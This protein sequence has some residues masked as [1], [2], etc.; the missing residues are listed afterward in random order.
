MGFWV[1]NLTLAGVAKDAPLDKVMKVAS[2]LAS[3][4][5]VLNVLRFDTQSLGVNFVWEWNYGARRFRIRLHRSPSLKNRFDCL[6]WDRKLGTPKGW[7]T[8]KRVGLFFIWGAFFFTK[9]AF[10]SFPD[11]VG[12]EDD[13]YRIL[14]GKT[15]HKHPILKKNYNKNSARF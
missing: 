3:I 11:R 2:C 9:K 13:L 15:R 6:K 4:L 14:G 8:V 10:K 12:H 1:G 7:L 5:G